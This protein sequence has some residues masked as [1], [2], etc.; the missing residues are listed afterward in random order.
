MPPH[1]LHDLLHED[2][3]GAPHPPLQHWLGV[4]ATAMLLSV[5]LLAGAGIVLS[6]AGLGRA[7]VN[8]GCDGDFL[9]GLTLLVVSG[10]LLGLARVSVDRRFAHEVTYD[11][12]RLAATLPVPLLGLVLAA[13]AFLGCTFALEV[14]E[15]G[16]LGRAL[17]GTPGIAVAAA[18]AFSTGFVLTGIIRIRLPLGA[19]IEEFQRMHGAQTPADEQAARVERALAKHDTD[20]GSA[21]WQSPLDAP[22]RIVD[23]R[24]LLHGQEG[25]V[26]ERPQD[27]R[28]EDV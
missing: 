18:C 20:Q 10:A 15:W 13:P 8:R 1:H 22:M 24:D 23:S 7:T 5:A 28:D 17:L 26:G 3:E 27:S 12:M 14:A 4:A 9:L 2:D 25:S 16:L 6:E 19:V 21:G 11:G